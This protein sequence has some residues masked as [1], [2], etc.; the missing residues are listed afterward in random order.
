MYI[1]DNLRQPEKTMESFCRPT[2][3]VFFEIHNNFSIF[4]LLFVINA[5]LYW[6]ACQCFGF[7]DFWIM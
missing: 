2:I 5:I 4:Y 3:F 1:L 7:Q 6:I